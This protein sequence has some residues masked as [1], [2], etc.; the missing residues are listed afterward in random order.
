[1]ALPHGPVAEVEPVVATRPPRAVLVGFLGSIVHRLGDW[2]PIG[3]AVELLG[4]AG[5]D[6]SRVRTG[7]S[8][9]KQRAWLAPEARAGVRGYSL[10]ARAAA[11][12]SAGDE[13][14][15]HA[16]EPADLAE[17]WCVVHFSVPESDRPRRSQLRARLAALG[18][19][20]VGAAVW[21]APAR[22]LDAARR[23]IDELGLTGQCALFV[24]AHAGGVELPQLVSGSWDLREINRGY[25]AFLDDHAGRAVELESA[26]R[27]GAIDGGDAFATYLRVI[28]DW[29]TLPF[30]D[31][32][33]PRELLG[34]DWA[35]AEAGALF[36]R[37]VGVLE[38][39]ALT[40]AA[41]Y[42]PAGAVG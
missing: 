16:R 25:R 41:Q 31:P 37:L 3:G 15:W 22:M 6:E 38:A 18:F 33:L 42:W 1:M 40:H 2:M 28:E 32:G 8:R 23:T 30:R 39:R 4:Q 36:E 27:A 14:V 11:E 26:A 29:R 17:G 19:G 34:E 7:V 35:A 21:I 9:L 12:L 13:I 10:T 20:N 24:G 5:V